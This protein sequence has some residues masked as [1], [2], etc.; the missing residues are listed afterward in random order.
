[1]PRAKPKKSILWLSYG[2]ST[3]VL[4]VIQS[5]FFSHFPVYG[6]SPLILIV[7]V[8]T[9]AVFEGGVSGAAYGLIC[10]VFMDSMS[11][12]VVWLNTLYY[13]VA[14]GAIGLVA[15][16]TKS[17]ALFSCVLWSFAALLFMGGAQ[18]AYHGLIL[19][20][21][22]HTVLVTAAAQTVYS[23]LFSFPLCY[24]FKAIHRRLGDD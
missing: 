19:G 24:W 6:A 18:L 22:M 23:L 9:V 12:G 13:A 20:G 4:L 14:G 11:S 1:M 15:S 10:G 17:G 16:Y 2:A 7:C 21:D 5:G 3:L 8:A